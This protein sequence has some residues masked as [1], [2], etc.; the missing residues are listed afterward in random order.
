MTESIRR[1][2]VTRLAI[3]LLLA[4]VSP[5]A[6]AEEEIAVLTIRRDNIHKSTRSELVPIASIV[7]GHFQA[8]AGVEDPENGACSP[9]TFRC[10]AQTGIT[11]EVRYRCGVSGRAIVRKRSRRGDSCAELW[12]VI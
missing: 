10:W 7:R 12:A 2:L 6:S 11:Y 8:I 5:I 3:L 9:A 1:D 4:F